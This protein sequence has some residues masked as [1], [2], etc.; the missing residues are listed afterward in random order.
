MVYLHKF[1]PRFDAELE[2][3]YSTRHLCTA[4][5]VWFT[6]VAPEN[7]GAVCELIDND[8]FKGLLAKS[9]QFEG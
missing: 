7:V 6:F 1:N 5:L 3:L 2:I 8:R 9:K 4:M